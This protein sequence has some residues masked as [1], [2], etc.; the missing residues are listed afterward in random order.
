MRR[1]SLCHRTQHHLYRH[2]YIHRQYMSWER[3]SQPYRNRL[4]LLLQLPAELLHLRLA[5]GGFH[6][7]RR[8]WATQ[9]QPLSVS[10]LTE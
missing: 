4:V 1:L 2:T 5:R 6:E 9:Y 8:S 7:L 3:S 10:Y